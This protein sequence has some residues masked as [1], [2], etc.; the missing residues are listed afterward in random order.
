MLTP[1]QTAK[2]RQSLLIGLSVV[3][4]AVT[5]IQLAS[6]IASGGGPYQ[7]ADWLIN[8]AAGQIRRGW[9][10]EAMFALANATGA[11]PLHLVGAVQSVLTTL[12]IA[13]VALASVR[14]RNSQTVFVLVASPTVLLFWFNDLGGAFRKELLVYAAFVPLLFPEFQ[15][16][17]WAA[18][19]VLLAYLA[20]VVGHEGNIFLA[21]ALAFTLYH[22]QTGRQRKLLA[23]CVVGLAAI[24]GAYAAMY[25]SI[26]SSAPICLKITSSGLDDN[27]CTGIVK[28]LELDASGVRSRNEFAVARNYFG[29]IAVMLGALAPVAIL[30]VIAARHGDRRPIVAMLFCSLPILP[31]FVL[32]ID[33][34]RW[35]SMGSFTFVLVTLSLYAGSKPAWLDSPLP[36]TWFAVIVIYNLTVGC[37]H[38]EGTPIPGPLAMIWNSGLQLVVGSG[39]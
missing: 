21:P 34:G 32:A 26:P 8:L 2:T 5:N 1:T 28:W 30:C 17:R 11:S 23:G 35:L 14:F 33:W 19:I 4:V 3:V 31:L 39:V 15:R 12:V 18:A 13:A 6:L 37:S 38:F 22:V 20:A 24:G 10:G 36:K 29:F 25:M 9:F 7:Q 16:T 27:L